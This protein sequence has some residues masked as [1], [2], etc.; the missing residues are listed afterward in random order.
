MWATDGCF[1]NTYPANNYVG[2]C[3]YANFT[4]YM[5]AY[6]SVLHRPWNG[7]YPGFTRLFFSVPLGQLTNKASSLRQGLRRAHTEG[8]AVELLMDGTNWVT[9]A[10]GVATGIGVC[11]SVASFNANATDPRD[12][13]DGVHFDIE[14]HT[15]GAGWFQNASA[16][17][18]RYNDFWEANLMSIFSTC[19]TLFNGTNATV[20]WDVPDDYYYY[21]KDLWRPLAS[22]QPYVDYLSIMSYHNTTTTLINGIG[23]LGGVANVLAS[24]NGTVPAMFGVELQHPPEADYTISFWS[25]GLTPMEAAL[26]TVN[27][28]FYGTAGYMGNSIHLAETYWALPATGGGNN[29]FSFCSNMGRV[30]H[31]FSNST[32]YVSMRVYNAINGTL[33]SINDISGYVPGPWSMPL[34]SDGPYRLEYYDAVNGV[35]AN[36]SSTVGTATCTVLL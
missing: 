19:R 32:S 11:Q 16:G 35:K 21:N 20:A 30:L 6:F 9:S 26:A 28:T 12:V 25:Q 8:V 22:G 14:P 34:F 7:T 3:G 2:N 17:T 10:S 15:L 18:D 33:L 36:N 27:A 4:S 31:A 23:G 29:T 1:F 24:L 5:D 13:F